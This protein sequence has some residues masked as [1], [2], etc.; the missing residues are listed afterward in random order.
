MPAIEISNLVH[1]YKH[2]LFER[3]KRVLDNLTFTVEEG[4]IFGFL[5]P[6]GAGKTTTIKILTSLLRQTSGEARVFGIDS[7]LTEARRHVGFQPES[8]Y[9]YDYLTAGEA[10][11]FYAALC[12]IPRAERAR[13][14]GELLEFV[15]LADAANARMGEFSKG[16]RQRL[17]I[18]QAIIHK[19]RLVI[20]DEPMSGLD[21][22]GR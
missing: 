22:V 11:R 18:A 19:P 1:E 10:L 9:F 3:R 14:A 2:H 15:G 12:G 5:G 13:R 7:R 21:P 6:N 4:E 20:L 16:M 8:P 17:G